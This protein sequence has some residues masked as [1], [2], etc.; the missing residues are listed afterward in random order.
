MKYLVDTSVWI[1][2][3][4]A[5]IDEL[6]ELLEFDQVL[7]HSAVIGEIACGAFK[8][9]GEVLGNLKLLDRVDEATPGEVLELIES[10]K[11]QGKGLGW[12]DCQIL[13][14]A[15]ISEAR[16]LTYDKAL[17]STARSLGLGS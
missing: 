12:V 4:K 8:N 15:L 11:L 1:S 5:P 3:I 2:H 7:I 16:L 10:H 14:S 9:R 17:A 6:A 13:A